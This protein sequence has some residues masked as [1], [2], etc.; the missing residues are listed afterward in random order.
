VEWA[1]GPV[2]GAS[3]PPRLLDLGAGT[4]KLTAALLE[5]GP[6]TAVE[7][8]DGMLDE[9]RARFPDVDARSGSAERIPAA[10]SSVDAVLVGQAWH[11]FDHD[12]AL[13][14]VARVLRPAGALAVLWNGDDESV[15]W[16]R[17]YHEAVD[18]ERRLPPARGTDNVPTLPGHPAFTLSR[19]STHPNPVRT[20][21]ERLVG[22]VG[23]QSWVLVSEPALRE[24]TLTRLRDYLATRPET[25]AGEF[26]LPLVTEVVRA[27]RK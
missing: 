9:L 5:F 14:E 15:E 2:L 16:V 22:S 17:G 1:L 20:T 24:R 13:L 8:D 21:A 7:P 19:Y 26:E 23:T 12:R 10:D 3:T 25:S 11:W 18:L 4:G 6:V 27:L